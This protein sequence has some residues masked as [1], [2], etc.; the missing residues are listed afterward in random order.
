MKEAMIKTEWTAGS[1]EEV[2]LS[3][4][5]VEILLERVQQEVAAGELPAA[6][7]AIA[8][9]GKV[10]AFATYG[11]ADN[12]SLFPVFSSTKAITS[13]AAWLL[14][15]A[16]ELDI[17]RKVVDYIPEFGSH[18][19]EVITV[20][21]LF[22]HTA[23]FPHAPFK[24][25]DWP[26]KATRYQR[27]Q[28]WKLTWSPGSRYEYHPTSSM[29]VIAELIERLSNMSYVEFVRQR[30]ALPLGLDDMWV[31]C[32]SD[33]HHRI[34]DVTH[35]GTAMTSD[36]YRQL[37][38]PEPPVTEVTEEALTNFNYA[39]AREIGVPGGGGIMSAAELALFYQALINDGRGSNGNQVWQPATIRMAT[40]VRTG[41]MRD[42]LMNQLVNRALGVVV[43]GGEDRNLRGFG[44]TNSDLAFGHGGAGGQVAWADPATG[45]SLGYC[46]NGHERNPIKVGRRG[47][48]ISNKAAV[49]LAED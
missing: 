19:K 36:D 40:E 43:A 21:Q 34:K 42:L 11:D 15:E 24:V 47:I 6:Q 46:T 22:T 12:H 14:I 27:F 32:P 26:D 39:P 1:P 7:V 18:G 37:G 35:V 30:I 25:T 44:H 5:K 2:G 23:G 45:I 29:W 16:G 20:E 10:A 17:S 48:S 8:R 9:H 13:A 33:Q 41:D 31:G 3:S 28:D 4:E 49:C 38:I